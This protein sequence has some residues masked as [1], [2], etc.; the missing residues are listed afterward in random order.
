MWQFKK[1][2]IR[3]FFK[4]SELEVKG[5]LPLK[6]IHV[7]LNCLTCLKAKKAHLTVSSIS[8]QNKVMLPTKFLR[9]C[10]KSIM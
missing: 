9:D 3:K 1:K 5:E 4:F 6:S 8:T 10:R 2:N 7:C